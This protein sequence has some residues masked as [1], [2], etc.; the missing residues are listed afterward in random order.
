VDAQQRRTQQQPMTLKLTIEAPMPPGQWLNHHSIK[1]RSWELKPASAPFSNSY[2]L[3]SSQ[4]ALMPAEA[5]YVDIPEQAISGNYRVQV[6]G[7]SS[8][9]ASVGLLVDEQSRRVRV[10][11]E[12][13]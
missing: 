4:G 2:L 1:Q 11:E 3:Q 9:F 7:A 8:S 12:L 6:E 10:Y 5:F 13:E